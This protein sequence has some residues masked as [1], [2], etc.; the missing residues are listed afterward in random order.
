MPC[1]GPR[2]RRAAGSLC[3]SRAGSEPRA[4]AALPACPCRELPSPPGGSCSASWEGDKRFYS[5]AALLLL[6]DTT[7]SVFCVDVTRRGA[8]LPLC[9]QV[10]LHRR[11]RVGHALSCFSR[12]HG[13]GGMGRTPSSE[14][15]GAVQPDVSPLP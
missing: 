14:W 9:F 11:T 4:A 8:F 10:H 13:E 5:I 6:S 3:P 15:N 1:R 2:C 12:N 7:V